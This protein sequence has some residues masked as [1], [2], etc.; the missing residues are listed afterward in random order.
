MNAADEKLR[1]RVLKSIAWNIKRA[2]ALIKKREKLERKLAKQATQAKQ[3]TV[4]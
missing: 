1:A 3:A 4:H 2:G